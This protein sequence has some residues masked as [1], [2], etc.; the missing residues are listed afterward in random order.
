MNPEK[1]AE[2]PD[3]CKYVGFGVI[4]DV[5]RLQFQAGVTGMHDIHRIND[6]W[7]AALRQRGKLSS[8]EP[9]QATA[10]EFIEHYVAYL[11]TQ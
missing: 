11:K 9:S 2:K 5:C 4:A 3:I 8:R 1:P 6:E 10:E 7:R